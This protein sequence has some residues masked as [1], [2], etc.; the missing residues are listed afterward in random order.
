M[1]THLFYL[2]GIWLALALL[3]LLVLGAHIHHSDFFTSMLY[4]AFVVGIGD[5]LAL[6]LG[7]P[8]RTVYNLSVV[9]FAIGFPFTMIYRDWNAMGQTF[10]LFSLTASIT[11]LGYAFLVTA[12]SPVSPIA[13]IISF[14]LLFLETL[15]LTLSLTYAYEVLDV[16]CRARWRRRPPA[17][18]LGGY[19]PMVSLHIPAYNEPPELVEQTLRALAGLDYPNFEVIVVDNNTPHENTWQP[20]TQIC[21]ELGFKCLHLD[22]WPGYKSGALNFALAMTDPHAEIVGVIDADY[23][24][25]PDWLRRIVPYFH[26]RAVAFVQTPQDYRDYEGSRFSQAE[27]DGY[28]YFFALS[29]PFRNER[30]AIIFCGTMGLLRK[31]VLQEIGGWDQWCIT[32]DA[33]AS[34]RILYRG[35][36]ALFV[37]ETFGRGLMPLDFE[38][39]KKQRFRWAFGGVQVIKKHWWKLMPWAP[40][41][42]HNNRLTW[43][44]RYVYLAAGLQWFN[45]LLTFAFTA[46]VLV[47]AAL[48]VTGHS[49][50]LRP[51]TEAFVTLPIVLIGT[52]ML[53][54]TWGLRQA[55]HL[56]WKRAAYALTLWFGLTWVV[57]LACIQAVVQRGGVFLRTPKAKTRAAWE[58][59]LQ[60][61]SF[62]TILGG[63]CIFA[64]IAAFLH[65]PSILTVGL[66]LLC[67][68]QAMIYLSAPSHS[69]L[70]LEGQT[71]MQR[72]EAAQRGEIQG[73]YTSE[74]RLGL[75]L[76]AVVMALLIIGLFASLWPAPGKLPWWY[77][78]LPQ[79]PPPAAP[80][81]ATLV[82]LTVPTIAPTFAPTFM[83]T[84]QPTVPAPTIS[85]PTAAPTPLPTLP[86]PTIAPIPTAGPVPTP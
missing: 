69:M 51:T 28:K 72:A 83:P 85:P 54:A 9:I 17:R 42:D 27:Y 19:V 2:V 78:L 52:N 82:P 80:V 23:I 49:A 36:Q 15:A 26:D 30:N 33:E 11:Y 12:F 29:M 74:S 24:V 7:I 13:F 21:H 68:S 45:E 39:L 14:L 31:S 62:E 38:S 86:V 53:R 20:L 25:R 34:L 55:L 5:Y 50:Y 10:F 58:R 75:Q 43:T 70:S 63:L 48:T 44:Q 46:M 18:T 67:F 56:S 41:V 4:L 35:Y 47:S 73:T 6:Y 22:K 60:V 71:A 57:T 16:L 40:W 65:Y 66:M 61:T 84:A 77:S 8:A 32:E 64:G 37:E 81:I 79:A 76:G 3:L 59:A 1:L